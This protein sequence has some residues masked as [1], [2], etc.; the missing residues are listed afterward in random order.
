MLNEI[1]SRALNMVRIILYKVEVFSPSTRVMCTGTR[2]R[3]IRKMTLG[4]EVRRSFA[5]LRS[6]L[7]AAAK[8]PRAHCNLVQGLHSSHG[9]LNCH[10]K[11]ELSSMVFAKEAGD[12]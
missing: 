11:R 1:T 6:R 2:A 4:Y 3:W 9:I 5:M 12:R 10:G 7:T 8:L